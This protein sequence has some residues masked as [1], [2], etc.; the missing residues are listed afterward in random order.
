[1]ADAATSQASQAASAPAPE[2][3][4]FRYFRAPTS[5]Q[6]PRTELPDHYFDVTTADIRA[7]QASLTAKRDALHNAP[8]RTAA[9]RDAE[10]KKR[11]ARW[12]QTT[13]RIKFADR[14]VLERTF[15]ST[16]KIKSVYVFVRGSLRED[17]KPI[18]FVL[19]QSPP[20]REYKVS[21][22]AVR[23]LTLAELDL[24]PSSLLLIK[25]IDDERYNHTDVPA[26][27]D[28]SILALAEDFPAPPV[29]DSDPKKDEKDAK[30]NR[31][32]I[33]SNLPFG[34]G[35][36]KDGDDDGGERK[37]P[38]WFKLGPSEY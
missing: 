17:V 24:A 12:P 5:A 13:I 36:K 37:Y 14:S 30:G 23:D 15:P 8:L 4:V 3:P 7:Q 32:G 1:M 31:S 16:D 11:R 2:K 22:P 9:L 27:L 18:K 6:Q 26:P 28:P 19:Y 29:Y 38:K 20:K 25:F 33:R 10:D 21:D 35:K 34:S